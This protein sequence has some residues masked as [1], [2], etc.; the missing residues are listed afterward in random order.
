MRI[1]VIYIVVAIFAALTNNVAFA[2]RFQ[3]SPPYSCTDENK[4]CLS[5]GIR[6]IDGIDVHKDCWEY[7]YTKTCNYQSK[8]DCKLY[9]SCYWVGDRE[10]ILKDTLGN[11]VN[12]RREFSCER[13]EDV[14]IEKEKA[15]EGLV[16][17]QE[18]GKLLCKGVPCIDG[19]CVDKS[20]LTNGEMM[21]AISKLHAAKNMKPDSAQNFNLFAGNGQHCSKKVAGYTNCCAISGG[22]GW[23]REVGAGC[24][25]DEITLMQNR[26]KNLCIYVGKTESKKLGVKDVT[27]HY[28]CCFGNMLDKVMQVEARR[29]LGQNF[30]SGGRPDCSGLNMD[31]IQRLDFSRIDFGEFIDE[32]KVKFAKTYKG[33]KPDDLES[34]INDSMRNIEKLDN[35]TS[36]D[37]NAAGWKRN[38]TDKVGGE[39]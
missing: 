3:V 11:C 2:A 20:Y 10:C 19:N 5:S 27:K 4:R 1:E 21:D 28:F 33:M 22:N 18:R 8:D 15:T 37:P 17:L 7:S 6:N 39:K 24:S 16:V 25:R 32:L 26:K 30:G 38:Y 35:S 29:Q 9:S 14:P 36:R 23:G 34:R 12:L 13:L 31:E